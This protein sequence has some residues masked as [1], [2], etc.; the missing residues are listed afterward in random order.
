MPTTTPDTVDGRIPP[1][2]RL[3][4]ESSSEQVAAHVR[5]RI[6]AGQL[7]KG[8]RLRQEDLAAELGLSRIPV[9]EAMIALDREGW[10][11]F[12]SN[13]GAFVAGFDAD[14]IVDHY[15]IR[16]LVFGLIGRR[17]SEVATA[18]DITRLA[19]LVH[20]MRAAPDLATFAVANDRAIGRLLRLADSPRLTAAL[21]VTPAI[22]HEGFF[23]FVPA[24]RAIQERGVA[25]FLKAVRARSHDAADAALCTMLR[26][27]GVAVLAA[28]TASGV[29]SGP[30]SSS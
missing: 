1:P 23:E 27:Q 17:V 19:A 29:V 11:H 15:E 3:T 7:R 21:L 26:R 14:D 20:E 9:R 6:M 5:H 12:E 2:R 16:G 10:L 18:D 8:D 13:R 22:V 4:R 30:A 28:F 24:G 25:A